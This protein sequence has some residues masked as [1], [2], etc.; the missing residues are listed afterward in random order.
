MKSAKIYI[1][2]LWM[3]LFC[4]FLAT[5][6]NIPAIPNGYASSVQEALRDS[7]YVS[8][9]SIY[10][11]KGLV[12]NIEAGKPMP[13][14][15]I[16]KIGAIPQ[17]KQFRLHGCPVDFKQ[18]S[19]FVSISGL[20]KLEVLE[21]RMDMKQLGVLTPASIAALRQLRTLKRLTLP[22]EYP[23]ADYVALQKQLPNCEIVTSMNLTSL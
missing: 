2:L 14:A 13:D 4:G 12:Y 16:E 17:L 15:P 8:S 23:D 11:T 22:A 6:Q 10:Y 7:A 3:F 18:Q 9:I 21:L 19:F 1:H 20:K 5:A